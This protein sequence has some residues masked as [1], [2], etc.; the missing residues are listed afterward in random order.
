MFTAESAA[1]MRAEGLA[2]EANTAPSPL[3]ATETDP[4]RFTTS[5]LADW[6][7][8]AAARII[9]A[10]RQYSDLLAQGLAELRRGQPARL[11]LTRL[12]PDGFIWEQRNLRW[13]IHATENWGQVIVHGI[14]REAFDP[15]RKLWRYFKQFKAVD[16]LSHS[17]LY[18]SRLDLLEDDPFEGRPTQ[19][20]LDQLVAVGRSIFGEHAP[21]ARLHFEN[22]RRATYACCWQKLEAE[23]AEMWRDY[24]NDNA[25]LAIQ[26]TERRL[27]HQ[28]ATIQEGRR[29]FYFR[30][31]DYIDHETHNPDSHGF[32]EQAFLK[33]RGYADERETRFVWF[34][35]DVFCGT[36]DE[37]ERAL[38]GLDTGRRVP[39]DLAAAAETVVIN[40][41]ASSGDRQTLLNLIATHQPPLAARVR[42]STFAE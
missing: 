17:Q 4:I 2:E 19:P 37:I 18:L 35:P 9:G 39:F 20:M 36:Q 31:V 30:E 33:R 32:P 25:G 1:R 22:Q 12:P 6:R 3:P 42:G 10:A 28:F 40:P 13:V 7:F 38:A 14:A 21:D 41:H 11:S 34:V 8:L 5:A 23:S 16:L 27:Q 29:L 26:S 15:F 24:C